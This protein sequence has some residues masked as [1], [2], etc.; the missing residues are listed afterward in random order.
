[1][2]NTTLLENATGIVGQI[3][4]LND[5]S[6]TLLISGLLVTLWIIAII[7]CYKSEVNFPK[8][9]VATG[10]GITIMAGYSWFMGWIGHPLLWFFIVTLLV[11]VFYVVFASNN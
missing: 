5:F 9:M 1:M 11:S 8:A 4:V 3:T 6:S 7:G 10:F 2:Y